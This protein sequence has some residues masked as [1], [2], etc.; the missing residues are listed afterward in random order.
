MRLEMFFRSDRGYSRPMPQLDTTMPRLDQLWLSRPP[1]LMI[2]RIVDVGQTA[3]GRGVVSYVLYD[4]AGS[5]LG[6]VDGAALDDGW[7]STFQP[8]TRRQG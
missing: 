4:E 1:Y 2:A 5:V 3:Q 6:H 8:L 7:W